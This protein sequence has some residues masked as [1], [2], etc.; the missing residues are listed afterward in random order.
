MRSDVRSMRSILDDPLSWPSCR[1][2]FYIPDVDMLGRCHAGQP[3]HSPSPG[4]QRVAP[5]TGPSVRLSCILGRKAAPKHISTLVLGCEDCVLTRLFLSSKRIRLSQRAWFWFH[6]TVAL[7]TTS[8]SSRQAAKY[9]SCPWCPFTALWT[10]IGGEGGVE[11]IHHVDPEWAD[12]KSDC[13]RSMG[14]RILALCF[15]LIFCLSL[16]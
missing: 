1:V 10:V 8:E 13:N 16:N 11:E 5:S 12:I 14:D 2:L 7:S 9:Q 3:I 4:L 15:V 6:L